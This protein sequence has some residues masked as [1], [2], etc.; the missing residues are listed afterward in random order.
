MSCPS[1]TAPI[2]IS[3]SSISGKCDLKCDYKFRYSNSSCVATNRGDYLTLS[4][5]TTSVP[6]VIY[7]ANGYNVQEVRIYCPSLH[8]FNNAK[9]DGEIIIVHTTPS[10]FR[11]LLVCVPFKTSNSSSPSA[12][13]LKAVID[14]VANTAPTDG[15]STNVN[16][17]GYNLNSVVP[18]QPYFAYTATEPYQPCSTQ[19]DYIVFN[20]SLDILPDSLKKLESVISDNAYDIKKGA[21]LF[22]NEKGPG[23]NIS[24]DEIYID[25]QPVGA[26]EETTVTSGAT[27]VA[28]T[29]FK[30]WLKNPIVQIVLGSLLFIVLLIGV[31]YAVGFVKPSGAK[32]TDIGLEMPSIKMNLFGKG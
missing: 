7:N 31:A 25:C 22:Y 16:Y 17:S 3:M 10:G 2:D 5:D 4:Y 13:L 24:S 12:N 8:S 28:P 19:C 21:K 30:D 15:E 32:G 18:K 6:P 27:D 23:K 9:Y 26:S 29:D 14:S 20:T 1:A 11:P